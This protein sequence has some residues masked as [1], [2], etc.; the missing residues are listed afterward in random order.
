MHDSQ[1][2][3]RDA[4]R[5]LGDKGEPK[6][7]LST[8]LTCLGDPSNSIKREALDTIIAGGLKTDA[9]DDE[10][11]RAPALRAIAAYDRGA[12]AFVPK[13]MKLI[14]DR[15]DTANAID[16]IG[17]AGKVD[18]ETLTKIKA[19]SDN[20]RNV[21]LQQIAAAAILRLY[22]DKP[23]VITYC[24]GK[25]SKANNN[26]IRNLRSRLGGKLDNIIAIGKANPD[27]SIQE[28]AERLSEDPPEE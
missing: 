22:P 1:S 25:M 28:V 21:Y 5:L 16:A 23:K 24:L 10:K 6:D 2:L 12:E 20:E 14:D 17:A 8:L 27:K 3:R 18:R 26:T 19:I 4:I 13:L 9:V 7:L 15:T 11:K